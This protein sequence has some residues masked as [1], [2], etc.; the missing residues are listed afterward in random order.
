MRIYIYIYRH[1]ILARLSF[2]YILFAKH[3]ETTSKADANVCILVCTLSFCH[4]GIGVNVTV[5]VKWS[6][7]RRGLQSNESNFK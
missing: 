2:P 4:T 6:D 1:K 5:N 7:E 3:A